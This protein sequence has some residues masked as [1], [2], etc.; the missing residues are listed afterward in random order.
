MPEKF[1]ADIEHVSDEQWKFEAASDAWSV[2][3]VA[4]HITLSEEP[5]VSVLFRKHC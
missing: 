4:E 3:E 1:L 2:G 5:V